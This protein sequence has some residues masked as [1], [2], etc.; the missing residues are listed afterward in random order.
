MT[1]IAAGDSFPLAETILLDL[2]L[3]LGCQVKPLGHFIILVTSTEK[4]V[5]SEVHVK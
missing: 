4:E 3:Q 1:F 5:I 2:Y